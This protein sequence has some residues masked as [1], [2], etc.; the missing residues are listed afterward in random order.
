MDKIDK[1]EVVE[2]TE[3]LADEIETTNS[4][5]IYLQYDGESDMDAKPSK[6]T[7]NEGLQIKGKRFQEAKG[8]RDALKKYILDTKDDPSV[9][10]YEDF[11]DRGFNSCELNRSK[12]NEEMKLFEQGK[13]GSDFNIISGKTDSEGNISDSK[14]DTRPTFNPDESSDRLEKMLFSAL[15]K[16]NSK[17]LSVEE[18]VDDKYFQVFETARNI[19]NEHSL[20]NM[21]LILGSPGIGKCLSGE[22]EVSIQVD[23]V[24]AEEIA[25]WLESRSK[26]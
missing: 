24:I 2:D 15:E 12:Y 22:E 7:V 11:C 13:F 10:S 1:S 8:A 18:S 17:T 16:A 19:A 26:Q 25:D 5:P 14:P 21:G 4:L 6:G 20:K 3:T 23:D 9:R